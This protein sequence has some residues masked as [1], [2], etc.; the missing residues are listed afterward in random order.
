MQQ[1]LYVLVISLGKGEISR[2]FPDTSGIRPAQLSLEEEH[3]HHYENQEVDCHK[4]EVVGVVFW[5]QMT[6]TLI[7]QDLPM[8]NGTF[9]YV[10][11]I[12]HSLSF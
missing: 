3:V 1:G 4:E 11:E 8:S 6:P 9:F 12:H 10:L 7:I 2:W 5:L